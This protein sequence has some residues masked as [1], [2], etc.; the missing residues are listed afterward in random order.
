MKNWIFLGIAISSEVMATSSLKVCAGFSKLW[1]SV[2]VVVGYTSAFYFLSLTL[3]SIPIGI[4]YALW[5]G[6]GVVLLALVGIFVFGQKLD[7]PAI[8]G[9]TLIVAGAVIMNVFST[10]V[11]Y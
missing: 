7:A 4:A 11:R 8:V 6:V 2:L 1:P 10:T 9:M 5:A 3:N